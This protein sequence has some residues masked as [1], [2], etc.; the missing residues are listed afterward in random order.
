MK[1]LFKNT[2]GAAAVEFTLVAL[3]ALTFI[4]GIM[5]TGYIVWAANALSISVDAAARC[6]ALAN[7]ATSP[8]SGSGLANMTSAA[9]T[10]FAP[11]S[12][13]SFTL[14]STCVADGGAGLVGTYNV[15]ILAVDLTLTEKSCYPSVSP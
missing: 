7:S 9:N 3:P 15:S 11:L 8:C 13:A 4:I 10:V 1:S 5:Q 6:G 12:G 2:R 14:N